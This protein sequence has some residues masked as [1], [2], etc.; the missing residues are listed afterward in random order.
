MFSIF[1]SFILECAILVVTKD[2]YFNGFFF[3]MDVIGTLSMILDVSWMS[4]GLGLDMDES[5]TSDAQVLRAARSAKV[6][7]SSIDD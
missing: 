6:R 1:I 4:E 3:Y 2:Q 7:A 5:S